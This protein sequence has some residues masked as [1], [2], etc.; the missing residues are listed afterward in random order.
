MPNVQLDKSFC[1][2]N[3]ALYNWEG[4]SCGLVHLKG[5]AAAGDPRA[6]DASD[7]H[8]MRWHAAAGVW[9]AL[10]AN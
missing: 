7:L 5:T 10:A 4:D 3:S 2:Q 6:R 1:H 9:P 8:S